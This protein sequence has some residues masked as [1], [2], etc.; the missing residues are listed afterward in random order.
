M[1]TS[2]QIKCPRCGG[3]IGLT[4]VCPSVVLRGR[5]HGSGRFE[6]PFEISDQP[7]TVARGGAPLPDLIDR[8]LRWHA[9]FWTV[10][11]VV[12]SAIVA[13]IYVFAP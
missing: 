5:V 8:D 4:C 2:G 13:I 6:G 12:I 11:F 3:S 1:T 7:P 9:F 10:A